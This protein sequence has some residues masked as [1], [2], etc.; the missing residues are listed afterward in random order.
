MPLIHPA[1]ESDVGELNDL[2]SAAIEAFGSDIYRDE[3]VEA[4]ATNPLGAAPYREAVRSES[5]LLVVAEVADEIA[6]FGRLDRDAEVV[7]AVYVH[8]DHARNGVGSALLSHLETRAREMELDSLTLHASLNA[9]LFYQQAGYEPQET[10]PHE[11][12]GGVEL[13]C[14]KMTKKL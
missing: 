2:H 14:V 3:Q 1:T 6:G 4:W 9:E 13:A 5:E 8:P 11:A 12:T 10:V 7:E